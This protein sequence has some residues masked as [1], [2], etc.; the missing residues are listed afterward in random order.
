MND[1]RMVPIRQL[2]DV[3]DCLE[4][5]ATG[6][7]GWAWED[8]LDELRA[9]IDGP[10]VEPVG[11]IVAWPDDF[12]RAGVEWRN[13]RP[14]VGTKLYPAAQSAPVQE[15][16][17]PRCD[18]MM[19]IHADGSREPACGC[20]QMMHE[21][22][23]APVQAVPDGWQWVPKEPTEEMEHAAVD[24]AGA[25]ILKEVYPNGK[26]KCAVSLPSD[27]FGEAYRAMLAAAP[28]PPAIQGMPR[29]REAKRTSDMS[30]QAVF[31]SCHE[32]STFEEMLSPKEI[33][34]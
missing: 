32:A 14:P 10:G 5:M 22:A 16:E 29:P 23:K 31:N 33:G 9:I 18:F 25:I 27:M 19:Q 2:T 4:A 12:T 11:E 30:V 8:V 26:Y 7:G 13:E 20:S 1:Q 28:Q 21:L 6:K 34:E 15:I 17:T 3:A 24:H